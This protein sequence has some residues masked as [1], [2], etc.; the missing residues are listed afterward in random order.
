MK[1]I[2]DLDAEIYDNYEQDQEKRIQELD[3]VTIRFAGDSGD[4]MQITGSQFSATTGIAG[5]AFN[6]FPD[7]PAEIRAPAGTVAGVSGFQI[8]FSRE[9]IHT[10]GDFADVLIA[11]NPAALKANHKDVPRGG[12]II[13]NEDAFTPED[14]EKAGYT[15]NPL[16]DDS[17]EVYHVVPVP[18][19]RLTVEQLKDVDMP[20]KE[21]RRSKNMFALGIA[22]WMFDMPLLPTEQWIE[23]KFAKNETL[24]KAN[25][26]AL[27][28]GYSFGHMTELLPIHFRIRTAHL[29]PGLYRS[30]TGNQA[31]SLGLVAASQL[32]N[33]PL[34]LGS[35][36]ITPASDILHELSRHKNFRIRTFQA[37]DEIAAM[38]SA[39]GAAYAGSLAVTSTSGPGLALKT[40]AMNLAVMAEL[41]VLIINVQRAGPST[42]MPTK[43]EQA[44]LLQALVGRSGE[45]PL[46]VIAVR[47]PADGF[48]K[49]IHAMQI[50]V[51]YM[52]PVILLS[53]GYLANGTEEWKLPDLSDL[54][55]FKISFRTEIEGFA[56]YLRDEHLARPWVKAGTPGLEH[57]IGGLEKQNIT[58]AVSY[59][60]ENHQSMV[61]LRAQKIMNVQKEVPDAVV[62]GSGRSNILLVGWGSTFGVI[63][64]ARLELAEEGIH[65]DQVHVDYIH[66]LPAN[67]GDILRRYKHVIVIEKNMGQFA[68]WLQGMYSLQVEKFNQM[69]GKPFKTSEVMSIVKALRSNI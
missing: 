53:D 33:V 65:V 69:N 5:N 2:T 18:I 22:F 31:I 42:G 13:V 28:A 21:K 32:A 64:D 43:V 25:L 34:F 14:L 19:T 24:K 7:F 66:P 8:H 50:A 61:Q 58:G 3:Q 52:T 48:R 60:G 49:A 26:L 47:S 45:S 67:L 36:P 23:K 38:A 6:T 9:E 41:P 57:R 1:R 37:E 10:S 46:P 12:V 39:I 59:D 15:S 27:R 35:Y 63:T 4:G 40:E 17:L 16:E 20:E 56:P 30:I 54:G 11:M 29:R 44:D 55:D 68:F 62:L 51:K